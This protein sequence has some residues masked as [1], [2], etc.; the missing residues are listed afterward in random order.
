[1]LGNEKID[2]DFLE[3][4]KNHKRCKFCKYFSISSIPS[5]FVCVVK[6]KL[7]NPNI[8]RWLCESYEA[9]EI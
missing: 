4:R 9:K 8:P 6:L 3:Y 2:Y 5:K 1:M 7:V